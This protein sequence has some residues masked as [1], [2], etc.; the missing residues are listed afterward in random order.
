MQSFRWISTFWRMHCPQFQGQNEYGKKAVRLC[1]QLA[2]KVVTQIHV[3]DRGG[4]TWS[5]PKGVVNRSCEKN[6]PFHSDPWINIGILKRDVFIRFPAHRSHWPSSLPLSRIWVATFLKTCP[7]HF[8]LEDGD[9]RFIRNGG[10]Y[11]QDCMVS[12]HRRPQSI[13]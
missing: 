10:I 12:Q 5:R 8:Y 4:R 11:L 1:R 6:S 9:S 2:W 7:T 13:L 3:S